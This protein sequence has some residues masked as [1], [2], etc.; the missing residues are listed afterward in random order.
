MEYQQIIKTGDNFYEWIYGLKLLWLYRL[1][2]NMWPSRCEN[3]QLNINNKPEKLHELQ[4]RI[5]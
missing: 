3:C 2:L 4:E 5:I 1:Y